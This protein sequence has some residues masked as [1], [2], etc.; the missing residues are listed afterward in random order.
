[1]LDSKIHARSSCGGG[2][3][4]WLE[5]VLGRKFRFLPT[6]GMT[7]RGARNDLLRK[8]K[9]EGRGLEAAFGKNEKAL[10]KDEVNFESRQ[11]CVYT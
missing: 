7:G 10:G 1:M 11:A 5:I 6:V 2:W 4:P 8:A 9:D 3:N